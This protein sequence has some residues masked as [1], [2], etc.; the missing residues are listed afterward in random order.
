MKNIFITTGIILFGFL[1]QAE[2]VCASFPV[3]QAALEKNDQLIRNANDERQLTKSQDRFQQ[4]TSYIAGLRAAN[5]NLIDVC[6][7]ALDQ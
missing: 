5:D 4:L 6:S 7:E 2:S 3:A 1:A